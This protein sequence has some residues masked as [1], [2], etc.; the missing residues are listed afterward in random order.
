MNNN[1]DNKARTKYEN[2]Q[3]SFLLVFTIFSVF[4]PCFRTKIK[5]PR[6]TLT[7]IMETNETDLEKRRRVR[8]RDIKIKIISP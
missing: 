8:V 6:R 1:Q 4:L 5:V 3:I 7:T 2:I